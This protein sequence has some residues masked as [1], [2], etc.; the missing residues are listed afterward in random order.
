MLELEPTASRKL[1][2]ICTVMFTG[3]PRRPMKPNIAAR[4]A[5]TTISGRK[6][7]AARRKIRARTSPTTAVERST[8]RTRLRPMSS[9]IRTFVTGVP[10]R[11]MTT[12]GRANSS[13][14]LC[15]AATISDS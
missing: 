14:T 1:G 15:T 9:K 13:S 6:T 10:A 2:R 7:P 11:V 12:S 8:K 5:K 3:D 4:E